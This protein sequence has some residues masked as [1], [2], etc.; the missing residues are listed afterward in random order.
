MSTEGGKLL[1]IIVCFLLKD[2]QTLDNLAKERATI[3]H[4]SLSNYIQNQKNAR[5]VTIK[6]LLRHAMHREHG[7][8]KFDIVKISVD[9]TTTR[10]TPSHNN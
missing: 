8:Q 6:S 4:I 7:I 9:M 1:R 3:P 10:V 5:G 2:I